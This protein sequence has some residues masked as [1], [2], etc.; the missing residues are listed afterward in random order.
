M[1]DNEDFMNEDPWNVS[2]RASGEAETTETS[3]YFSADDLGKISMACGIISFFFYHVLFAILGLVFGI[4]SQ[5]KSKNSCATVGIVCS[6][7][8]L[9]LMFF[10]LLGV[11]AIILAFIPSATEW[12]EKI[13]DYLS[14]LYGF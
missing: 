1:D 7:I 3:S 9:A 14:G 13:K 4:V 6:V 2:G 11:I 5:S 12:F 10:V 8:S